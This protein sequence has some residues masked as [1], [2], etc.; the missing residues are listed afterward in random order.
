MTKLFQDILKEPV[1]LSKSL[2]YY[3]RRPGRAALDEAANILKKAQQVYLIGNWQQLQR[4]SGD[5]YIFPRSRTSGDSFRRCGVFT[6]RRGPAETRQWSYLSRSGK[7]GEIVKLLP[8]LTA[9]GARSLRSHNTP[10][11]P[12]AKQADVVLHMM[13]N[14]DN[15]VLFH[16][17]G[18]G[19]DRRAACCCKR[20]IS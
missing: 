15:A 20:R 14:F 8:K 9:R 3:T 4:R 13:A 12:L 16:V 1:E 10:E 2:T 6:F 18:D 7:S 19:T 17:F 5:D 11:S